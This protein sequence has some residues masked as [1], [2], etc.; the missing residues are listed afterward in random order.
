[1]AVSNASAGA[2]LLLAALA[3][4]SRTAPPEPPPVSEPSV[5]PPAD[6]PDRVV[7]TEA[8]WRARLTP[9]QYHVTREKGTE[10]AFTGA[11]WNCDEQGTYTCI[12]CGAVLFTSQDKFD[13]GCGWPSFDKVAAAG[14]VKQHLDTSHGMVRTEVTCARCDAHLG[15]VFPDGPTETG[16]RYCINSAAIHLERDRERR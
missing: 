10:R 13:A 6:V 4:C 15:H 7:R 9:M 3:A 1:M 11:Y 2:A 14:R 12:G 5:T 8:E 16:Q